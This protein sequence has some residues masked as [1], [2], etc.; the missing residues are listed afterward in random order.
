MIWIW[1][2]LLVVLSA[3]ALEPFERLPNVKI[4]RVLEQNVILVNR[5]LEDGIMK[6]DHAK[7]SSDGDGYVTRAICLRAAPETSYWRLYRLP[8]AEAISMDLTYTIAGMGDKEIPLAQ[9]KWRNRETEI[10]EPPKPAPDGPNPFAVKRDLPEQLTE[11]DLLERVGP[12]R[13]KLLVEQALNQDQLERDL[14]DYR[15][16]LY[17]SPFMR[18]SINSSQNYR[19]GFRGGNFGSKYRL[20]TQY[21]HQQSRMTDPSTKETVSTQASNG[22]V[23]FVVHH[24]S[25]SVSS[26]SLVN[27]N[28]TYFSRFGTP[29]SHWQIGPIG[30]T[31]HLFENKNWEFVDLS[32]VPLLDLRTTDV[33]ESNGFRRVDK[34]TGLRHGFRF[35]LRRRINEHVALENLLWVRPFQ[36]LTN[37]AIESNNLN[38]SNDFKLV[39]TLGENFYLDYNFIYQNDRL[40][41]Q[42]SQLPA[43]NSIN[44]LNFRYDF[45]L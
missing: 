27:Y 22:Q 37:W 10:Y 1:S 5:G 14:S 6:D 17:A 12:E 42:L 3:V 39:F 15:I 16:S 33:I 43:T 23:Q 41:R 32:Y 21:E 45:S 44:S 36:A 25:D 8:Y 28:S 7:F 29:R 9:A 24:L 31:W 40:W 11:R 2:L 13:R 20:L 4:L 34:T 30:F 38:L 35:S 18:Q 19:Y 26:L